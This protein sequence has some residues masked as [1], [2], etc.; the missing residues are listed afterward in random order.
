MATALS[1]RKVI[2][3]LPDAQPEQEDAIGK[4]LLGLHKFRRT[5]CKGTSDVELEIKGFELKEEGSGIVPFSLAN[6]L[7]SPG[8]GIV[9]VFNLGR[10]TVLP[11]L[12]DARSSDP[13]RIRIIPASKQVLRASGFQTLLARIQTNAE[14]Q[15]RVGTKG[16][17][18]LELIHSAIRDRGNRGGRAFYGTSGFDFTHILET[19]AIS[20]ANEGNGMG[21][22]NQIVSTANQQWETADAGWLDSLSGVAFVGGAASL[23]LPWVNDPVLNG[24]GYFRI[25]Q[26]KNIPNVSQMVDV[27]GWLQEVGNTP[28]VHIIDNGYSFKKVIDSDLR[29]LALR[30]SISVRTTKKVRPSD[31]NHPSSV[32]V[33][34]QEGPLG[35]PF[36]TV[37]GPDAP[38]LS[39]NA[40]GQIAGDKSEP[41]EAAHQILSCISPVFKVG[42]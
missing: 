20:S 8:E 23:A 15:T 37:Y 19:E 13:S 35:E 30:E 38:D 31:L 22:L 7:I 12:V 32:L 5:T 3:C 39:R 29:Q 4:R 10:K 9:A 27:L 14:M 21:W 36:R 2:S 6:N 24:D 33:E 26:D 34:Y 1:V 28:G 40:T 18:N 25:P 16:L 41:E 17:P 42:R 11:C